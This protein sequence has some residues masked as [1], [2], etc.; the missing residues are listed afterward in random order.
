MVATTGTDETNRAAEP[1]PSRPRRSR[2]VVVTLALAFFFTPAIAAAV[3][4]RASHIEN[5][6]LSAFPAAGDGWDVFGDFD[7]WA[8]DHLPLRDKAIKANTTVEREIFNENPTYGGNGQTTT[9]DAAGVP[10]VPGVGVP[11]QDATAPSSTEFPTVVTGTDGWLF[12]GTDFRNAC[13]RTLVPAV[14]AERFQRLSEIVRDAGKQFVL[15]IPPDK[16]DIYPEYVP[17]SVAAKSCT[18]QAEKQFWAALAA[19]PPT[20]YHDLRSAIAQAKNAD[21]GTLLY[22]KTDTHWNNIGSLI[23]AK[24]LADSLDPR[25]WQTTQVRDLGSGLMNSDLSVL[26]GAPHHEFAD[27]LGI[28]RPGVT[29]V[30]DSSGQIVN[31]TTG[32]PLVTKRSLLISDSFTEATRYAITPLFEKANLI[33]SNAASDEP[34]VLQSAIKGAEIVVVEI[35]EREVVGGQSPILTQDFLHGLAKALGES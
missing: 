27:T 17:D 32:A 21:P 19:K 7:T 13:Q 14:T 20:G 25:L 16:T 34:A 24:M 4:V 33:N 18:V 29:N 1:V 8:T 5:H 15:F 3:G 30:V 35:V 31:T 10:G 11:Q 23:Y 26:L 2:T 6:K 22:R 28:T 9:T 12:Y